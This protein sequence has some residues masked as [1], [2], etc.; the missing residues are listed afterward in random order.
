MDIYLLVITLYLLFLVGVGVY[1]SRG[2]KDQEGFMVAGRS[3]SAMFLVATLVCTWIGSR[4]LFAG[5]GRAFRNGYS[6]L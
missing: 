4:S 5:A 6:A 2:V 3:V 1:R